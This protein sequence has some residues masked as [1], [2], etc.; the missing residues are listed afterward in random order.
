MELRGS[1]I[2]NFLLLLDLVKR[3]AC[4]IVKSSP[5]KTVVVSFNL[6][7]KLASGLTV[8]TPTARFVLDLSV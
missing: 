5:A 6:Y 4:N 7:E 3:N 1:D 2:I 8:C